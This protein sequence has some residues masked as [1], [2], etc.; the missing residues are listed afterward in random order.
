MASTYPV[1]IT[2]TQSYLN[3]Y[4]TMNLSGY[5]GMDGGPLEVQGNDGNYY[6]AGVYLGPAGNTNGLLVRELDATAANLIDFANLSATERLYVPLPTPGIPG[7]L[8][9]GQYFGTNA[10]QPTQNFPSGLTPSSFFYYYVQVNTGPPA[11]FNSGARWR[12]P[13]SSLT[14]W[15]TAA[16]NNVAPVVGQGK[17][18]IEFDCIRNGSFAVPYQ[19]PNLAITLVSGQTII[20]DIPYLPPPTFPATLGINTGQSGATLFFKGQPHYSYEIDY[21]SDL[22][23]GPWLPLPT[24]QALPT[25]GQAQSSRITFYDNTPSPCPIPDPLGNSTTRFY[26]AKWLTGPCPVQ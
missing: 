2:F 19:D 23:N 4:S 20:L 21:T 22:I 3:V 15:Y 25:I 6:P 16:P 12:V 26:R 9:A 1:G 18:T 8:D 13:E 5:A 7:L 11:A 17:V 14:T 24:I 10:L